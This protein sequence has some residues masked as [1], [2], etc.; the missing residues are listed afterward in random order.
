MENRMEREGDPETPQAGQGDGPRPVTYKYRDGREDFFH[1]GRE[2]G[3]EGPAMEAEGPRREPTRGAAARRGRDGAGTNEIVKRGLR[4]GVV[5]AAAT[6]GTM[7]VASVA[8]RGS[9]WAAMNAMATAI[10][11]G[12]RRVGDRFDPAITPAGMALLAGSLLVWGIAYE[13]ALASTRRRSGLLTGALSGASGYA[14]DRLLLPKRVI[15]NFRRKMGV[16]GTTGKYVALG[17]ASAAA[18]PR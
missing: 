5:L 12:G 4:T 2:A 8:K 17:L 11:I 6:A 10:G 15:P 18:S 16:L 7:M 3:P 13:G 9:P 14:F 1:T